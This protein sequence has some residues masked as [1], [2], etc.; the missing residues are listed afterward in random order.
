M[1]AKR[2][3]VPDAELAVLKALWDQ[4]EATIREIADRLYPGGETS[5]Y[6]TVQKLLDRLEETDQ[7]NPF[8][9]LYRGG[10]ALADHDL[11]TALGYM[12]QAFRA[13][14]ELPEVHVGLVRVYLALGKLDRARHHVGRALKLDATHEEA[15]KYAEILARP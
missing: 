11:E 8:F 14:S 7:A 15:R 3:D 13:D 10:M 5:H 12:R 1:P 6:A 4:G 2:P 9:Y